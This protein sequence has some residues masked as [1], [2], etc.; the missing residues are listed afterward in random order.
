MDITANRP[1]PNARRFEAGTPAVVNCYAAEAGL[2]IILEVGTDA[3]EERVRALTSRCMT[4][5]ERIGLAS[6][7]PTEDERR[8]PMV[9]V[10][11]R[12]TARLCA[13]LMQQNIVTSFRDNNIRAT[14]HFYNSDDDIDRFVTALNATRAG[15]HPAADPHTP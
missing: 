6:V 1:A 3:I 7:T 10:P 14:V 11:A 2:K 5:L 4:E 12:D 15:H 13:T 8:G 9:C